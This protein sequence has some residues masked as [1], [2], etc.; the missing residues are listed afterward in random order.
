MDSLAHWRPPI[1]LVA[2]AATALLIGIV[3]FPTA[4]VDLLVTVVQIIIV[5]IALLA[6]F[7]V[8]RWLLLKGRTSEPP[9]MT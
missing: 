9:E 3:A 1:W 7:A 2:I 8:A 4:L 5:I 6:V